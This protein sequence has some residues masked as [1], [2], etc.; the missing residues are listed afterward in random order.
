M[1]QFLAFVSVIMRPTT[2]AARKTLSTSQDSPVS[3]RK[4]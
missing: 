4:R 2:P 1:Y 3:T